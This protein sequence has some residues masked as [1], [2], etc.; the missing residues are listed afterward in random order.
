MT[1]FRQLARL[2]SIALLAATALAAFG[3]N[4]YQLQGKVIRGEYSAVEIVPADDPRLAQP[5]LP[6]VSIHL[7]SDPNKLN[8]ETIA[9]VTS[10]G[11]GDFAIP[12]DLAGAGFLVYDMGLFARK[13]GYSPAETMFRLPSDRRRVLITLTRGADRDLGED[14]DNPL[15]DFDDFR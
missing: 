6:G 7:Q 11:D 8:R 4:G 9:R 2:V 1:R 15:R 5:G 12:V 13:E 10:G 3:C 14:L